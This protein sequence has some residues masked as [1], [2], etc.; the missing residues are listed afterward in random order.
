LTSAPRLP[1]SWASES[2]PFPPP[3]TPSYFL[4]IYLNIALP[5]TPESFKW[6]LSLR[7]P[8]QNLLCTSHFPHMW[9]MPHPSYSFL[10]DHLN[11]IMWG[12]QVMKLS[13]IQFPLFPCYHV[14]LW[15]KY[16]RQYPVFQHPHH[17]CQSQCE[18]PGFTPIQ[19]N[20]Q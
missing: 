7:F 19:K 3:P 8:Y 16:R 6:T 2:S 17:T 4:K 1:L 18:W 13:I 14:P 9:Y 20:R 10:F 5:S 12:A 15:L 11:N